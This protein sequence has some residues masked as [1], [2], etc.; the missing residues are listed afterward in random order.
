MLKN[1]VSKVIMVHSRGWRRN[2][3]KNWNS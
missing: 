1:F 2:T 3:K